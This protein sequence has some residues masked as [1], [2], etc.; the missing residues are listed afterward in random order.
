[1]DENQLPPGL[2]AF[3]AVAEAGSF[4]GAAVRL[5]VSP[6]AVSQQVRALER[7]LGSSLLQRT[8]RSLRL[9]E[10][11]E[12]Y[13]S[14]VGPAFAAV[15]DATRVLDGDGGEPSGVLRLTLPRTA[16]RA[17]L[18]PV[19]PRFLARHPRV[20]IELSVDNALVDIVRDGFDAGIRFGD[21]VQRDMVAVRLGPAM[22]VALLASPGYLDARGRP[23]HPHDLASHDCVGFRSA[24]TG[25]V[26]AWRLRKGDEEVRFTPSGRL[27]VNSTE[28]LLAAAEDG[29]GIV[30]FAEE[31]AP[32]VLR[33]G[34][35]EGVLD[36]WCPDLPAFHLYYPDRRRTSG[37]LQALRS[38]LVEKR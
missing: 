15:R 20:R 13:R 37:A 10:A 35:L 1:M 16:Y 36:R 22:R 32:E 25:R 2:A 26:E 24:T 28:A 11:G 38:M 12:R 17:L 9:S 30:E 23:S 18:R 4:T 7:H 34:R 5:G 33:D 8:T 29:I 6:S 27:V 21:V 14:V 3:L 19:L 31:L